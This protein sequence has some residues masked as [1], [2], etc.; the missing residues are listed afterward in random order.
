[1]TDGAPLS[2]SVP[3]RTTRP[4][5]GAR[6][7]PKPAALGRHARRRSLSPQ[8]IAAL[9]RGWTTWVP[10]L[11][12][13]VGAYARVRQWAGGRS[14]WLD[15]VLIAD[16]LVR[17]GFVDLVQE[18]LLHSQ[19]A[20]AIWLW[21]ERLCV[22]LF[23]T[24]E[25]SLR[26]VPL[27]A[28]LAVLA[29]ALPLARQLL[30]RVLV[31]VPVVV[32]AL[33]PG[34]IYYSNEVKQYSTDVLAVLV[35]LLLAF[36]VRAGAGDGPPLRRLALV[37]AVAVWFSYAAIFVLAGVSVVLVV[38]ALRQRD[39]RRAVRLALVL[40]TWVLSLAVEYLLLLR[41]LTSNQPLSDYWRPTY[42]RGVE[43][44][45]TWF[46]R[47]WSDLA[48]NPLELTWGW[49]GLLLLAFGLYRL[50][51]KTGRRT[52]LLWSAVPAAM[53]AAALAAYPFAGRLALWLV[54]IAAVTLAAALP[55]QLQ[56][57]RIAWLLLGSA[58]LTICLA[59]AALTGLSL[60]ARTQEVEELRPLLERFAKARQPGDLVYVE[61]ATRDPFEY[62]AER[63]GVSR[64][65][66][67]LFLSR[68]EQLNCSDLA[69]LNAGRFA[70]ER[71]WIISGHRLTD[72]ARLGG[73]DDMLGR[74]RTVSREV[75][76][77][78]ETD[79]DAWLFDPSTGAEHPYQ[80]GDRNDER[81]LTIIRSS[82]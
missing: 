19:A 52:A 14:L 60:T 79:A 51:G 20:P 3:P 73:I 61:V 25:R 65:G 37:G 2:V 42:P 21:L 64:D 67:I 5:R 23:G 24:S 27:V 4:R 35:V 62:Y 48:S 30:P 71:V 39:L 80:R 31:P 22:T 36:R 17:R 55:H 15:E 43:D 28:G 63:T 8:V 6:A 81:C 26:V 53:T 13:A 16:N 68:E 44:L 33:H 82:R 41:R 57:G 34:L 49:L 56:Q 32:I 77:L 66:V 45:P 78:H 58:A 69:A 75:A 18:P 59:P 76:H 1:M 72:T 29:L 38:H 11:A 9:E 70:T 46:V 74:I 47:R 10:A 54:P 50:S 12:L 7:A 40:S